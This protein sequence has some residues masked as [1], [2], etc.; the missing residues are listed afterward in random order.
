MKKNVLFVVDE[1]RMGGV[2]V[3][4]EDMLNMI[5]LKKYNIDILCLHDNG[6]KLNDLPE[7]VNLIFG[8]KYFE[9]V[10]FSINEVLKSKNVIKIFNK[11]RL[12]F[13]MKT[14]LIKRS[15][16]KERKKILNKEYDVEIAFKDGFTA[17]FTIFG[18]SKKKVHWLHYEYLKTNPNKNYDK[19]FK[20]ILPKFDKIIA[21]SKGVEDAF[22]NIYHL[23]QLTSVIYNLIDTE[24]IKKKSQEKVE[25]KLSAKDINIVSVGRLHPMKGYERLI[26]A[27]NILKE[28]K[29]LP[30][31]L[32][33]RIYGDGPIRNLLDEKI[34][35]YK[36]T[37]IIKLMGQTMNPYK[38]LKG[39]DLFV[40]PSHYEP[41]GLVMVEAM[42]VNVP[43]MA[44]ENAATSKIIN[45]KENGYITENS[46]K[47][48]EEGLLYLLSNLDE[49]KKYQKNLKNY[50]YENEKIIKQIENVLDN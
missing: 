44:T 9:T 24:K 3:L 5:E 29:K 21:V 16:K 26:E 22:N 39:N 28:N 2:S 18:H 19:L 10:D 11:L 36:L 17:I 12:I 15:I 38:Y 6:E 34:K 14:G 7:G 43:V 33:V 46:T 13:E 30:K 31:N 50:K 27:I 45:H 37:N 8:S 40:L 20:T 4:L 42:T 23:E 25:E 1:R 32:K 35:E 48:I 49:L 47:G 41:F